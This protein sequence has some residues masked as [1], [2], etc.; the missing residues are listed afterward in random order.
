MPRPGTVGPPGYKSPVTAEIADR[1][2]AGS[3]G[4]LAGPTR[5]PGPTSKP[6]PGQRLSRC[7][8][9]NDRS[10]P[11]AASSIAASYAAAASAA[12]PSRRSRSARVAWYR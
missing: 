3:A 6:G 4:T 8:F 10:A 11:L 9:R 12:R 5:K 2:V 1:D 7:F